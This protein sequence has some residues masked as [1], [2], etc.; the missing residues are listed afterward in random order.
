M[1]LYVFV[2]RFAVQWWF[3]QT[4][5]WGLSPP[6]IS[7]TKSNNNKQNNYIRVCPWDLFLGVAGT[8][9]VCVLHIFVF[10]WDVCMC[11]RL[12]DVCLALMCL[13]VWLGVVCEKEKRLLQPIM[14]STH[15][16]ML[17]CPIMHILL[18]FVSFI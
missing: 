7:W 2:E 4:Y 12:C 10:G 1:N 8:L 13:C 14:P 18:N 11:L 15:Y 16:I 17:T 6:V 9:Y 5:V 3:Y